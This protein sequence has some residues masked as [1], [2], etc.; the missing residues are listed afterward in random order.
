MPKP[1][2]F[3]KMR[4]I[5]DGAA[6]R[7]GVASRGANSDIAM[8][9]SCA[10]RRDKRSPV[11]DEES[12]LLPPQAPAAEI[13]AQIA[14]QIA[15]LADRSTQ[16]M[17]AVRRAASAR[18]RP[19]SAVE[20][21]AVAGA[22]ISDHGLGWIGYEIIAAH[23]AAFRILTETDLEAMAQG[24]T[25]WSAVDALGMILAGPAWRLGLI[26]DG[27]VAGWSASP[28]RWRRRLSLV[29]TVPLGR[30]GEAGRVLAICDRLAGDRDDMVEKALSWALR[31]LSKADRA[32]VERFLGRHETVLGARVKREVRHKLATG[33]KSPRR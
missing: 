23:R 3:K 13:A 12:A 26:G 17:R 2:W 27:L 15:A 14:D 19:M 6:Q 22:L 18:L 10:G 16:P 33:L 7:G 25:S 4:A 5:N 21:R 29:A 1:N 24:L 28:D 11:D 9:V 31:E 32:A 20:A 30:A 8:Q